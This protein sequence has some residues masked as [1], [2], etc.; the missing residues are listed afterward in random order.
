MPAHRSRPAARLARTSR[1]GIACGSVLAAGL[2]LAA[3]TS[4]ALAA[5]QAGNGATNAAT[6]NGNGHPR[7]PDG[8]VP[9]V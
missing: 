4:P 1:R 6:G 7:D 3:A 9:Y 2:L 8:H 5:P